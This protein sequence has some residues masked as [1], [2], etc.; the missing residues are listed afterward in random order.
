MPRPTL[1][2]QL[3]HGAAAW[4]DVDVPPFAL[5]DLPERVVQFGTGAFLRGFVEFFIDEANRKGLFAG[6]IV[7]VGSMASGRDARI[8]EQDG[9]YTLVA[10]GI[11]DGEPLEQRRIIASLSRAL[12]AQNEWNE[13]LALA[14]S[15]EL[16]L[17]V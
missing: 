15:P 5:L 12:S 7:A 6:R 9:L 4:R 3:L 17:V 16:R 1:T 11:I 10:R 14:R 13:V 2:R 8:N